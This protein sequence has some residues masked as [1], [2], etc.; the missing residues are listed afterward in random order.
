MELSSYLVGRHD[1][2]DWLISPV[3][4]EM[5]GIAAAHITAENAGDIP[6]R[7]WH[8][9]RHARFFRLEKKPWTSLRSAPFGDR[10]S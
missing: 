4:G 7:V 9:G 2:G 8:C 3:E 5:S 6:A 10:A 1:A